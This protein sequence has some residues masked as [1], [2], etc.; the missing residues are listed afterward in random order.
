MYDKELDILFEMFDVIPEVSVCCSNK[1]ELL[2]NSGHWV[3][4]SCGS[5]SKKS[6]NLIYPTKYDKEQHYNFYA[7]KPYSPVNNFLLFVK[8]MFCIKNNRCNLNLE[9][10]VMFNNCTTLCDVFR[11]LKENKL[12]QYY[13]HANYIYYKLLGFSHFPK[14]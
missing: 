11:V 9:E 7:H 14:M 3:C 12:N 13:P 10:I 1:N 2:S 5:M 4:I 8:A 6:H